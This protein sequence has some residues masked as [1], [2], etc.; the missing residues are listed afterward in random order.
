MILS[1]DLKADFYNCFVCNFCWMFKT[2]TF[3]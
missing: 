2:D 1:V 3:N